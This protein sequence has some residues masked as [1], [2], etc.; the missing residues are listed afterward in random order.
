MPRERVNAA[1]VAHIPNLH[2]IIEGAGDDALAVGIEVKG[3]NLCGVAQESVKALARL[4][5]PQASRVVHRASR[6]HGAVRVEGEAHDL[7]GVAAVGV[8]QLTGLGI[9]QLARLVERAGNDL[10]TIGIVERDRVNDV[11]VSLER[12]Q[13]VSGDCVPDLA[14]AIVTTRNKL[15]SRLVECAVGQGEDVRPEDLEQ[16]EVTRLVALQ[17]LDK[18]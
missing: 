18:L 5:V 17:L 16:E 12:V 13:F 1:T 2:G 10:I 4:H 7:R 15:I 14:R 8:V 9:P 6:H 3:H 11:P